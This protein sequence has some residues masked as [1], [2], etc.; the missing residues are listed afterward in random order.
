M[1]LKS[2]DELANLIIGLKRS[3]IEVYNN[4]LSESDD[5]LYPI[6][7]LVEFAFIF[8]DHDD[9]EQDEGGEHPIGIVVGNTFVVIHNNQGIQNAKIDC[10]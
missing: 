10:C 2:C 4:L 9:L 1:K 5:P 8:D 3:N 7:D 6:L